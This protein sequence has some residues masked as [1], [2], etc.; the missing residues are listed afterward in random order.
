M[1]AAI[2]SALQTAPHLTP[3][4]RRTYSTA[5]ATIGRFAGWTPADSTAPPAGDKGR[6]IFTVL[7]EPDRHIPHMFTFYTDSP[8]ALLAIVV[9]ACCIFK[10]CDFLREKFPEANAVWTAARAKASQLKR[11]KMLNAGEMAAVTR[12]RS[13][14]SGGSR[15]GDRARSASIRDDVRG[16][17]PGDVEA[18]SSHRGFGRNEA[19]EF[20][21]RGDEGARYDSSVAAALFSGH[22][23]WVAQG[24]A[25]LAPPGSVLPPGSSSGAHG[26]VSWEHAGLAETRPAGFESAAAGL[27]ETRP[28]GFARPATASHDGGLSPAASSSAAEA[29]DAERVAT[30]PF[31]LAHLSALC[32]FLPRSLGTEHDYPDPWDDQVASHPPQ[33]PSDVPS[34]S[35]SMGLDEGH[36]QRLL[37]PWVQWFYANTRDSRAIQRAAASLDGSSRPPH[38][39]VKSRRALAIG[40]RIWRLE[41]LERLAATRK[42]GGPAV[43]AHYASYDA[44]TPPDQQLAAE[45]LRL[46]CRGLYDLLESRR[47]FDASKWHL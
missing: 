38:S 6:G 4:T 46:E 32:A 33:P 25:N 37:H 8:S 23:P 27:A 39:E 24:M 2:L 44:P 22:A 19:P 28:A 26:T 7:T 35:P 12:A 42:A 30:L 11:D 21:R 5:A 31:V 29:P 45:R 20:A 17:G 10:H 14:R 41:P 16:V 34:L 47:R 40:L 3:H 1:D 13:T 18:D 43:A 36:A 9:S 15:A